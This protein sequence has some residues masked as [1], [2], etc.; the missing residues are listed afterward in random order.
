MMRTVL[1]AALCGVLA[2]C[3]AAATLAFIY[4]R[5]PALVLEFDR[6]LPRQ[7]TGVYPIERDNQTGLTYAWTGVEMGVRAPGLDRRVAWTLDVRLRAARPDGRAPEVAFFADGIHLVTQV[8]PQ[9]FGQLRVTIP[10]SAPQPGRGVGGRRDLAITMRVSDTFTPGP[11]DPRPLGVLLDRLTLTPAGIVL[12]PRRAFFS[13]AASAGILG[14][15]VALLGVTAPAAVI[16]ALLIG[17][18][19]SAL[20]ARG[21]APFGTFPL[22]ATWLALWT[23]VILVVVARAIEWRTGHALRNT[24]RFALAFSAFAAF[25]KLLVMLHPDLPIGDALFHAHRFRL[26]DSGTYVFTSIAP[27]NYRFPYAPGLYVA[28]LPFADTVTRNIGDMALLR[29]IVIA[30]DAA[31]AA[32]LYFA[33]VRAWGDRLAAAIAVALYHLVPLD[34]D[35]ATVGNLT[36]AFAQSLAVFSLVLVASPALRLERRAAVVA[37]AGVMAAAFLSH[38]STFALL[39]PAA[40]FISAAFLWKGG[41][42]LRSPAYAVAVAASIAGLFAVAIYYRHFGEVYAEQ[43]A[44]ISGETAVNAPDAGGRTPMDRLL[45]AP[46]Q[47]LLMFGVP[48]LA[49]AAVGTYRLLVRS[50][51]DRLT[52]SLLGWSVSCALFFAIGIATPVDMRYY[53]AAI[54]A[55]AM[56]A[57]AGASWMWTT[58]GAARAGAAALLLWAAFT[59]VVGVLRF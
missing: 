51:R 1:R 15:A 39:L 48:V 30:F 17:G 36:N 42:A 14:A 59:G 2:A 10:T 35:I 28:A 22:H 56:T 37:L 24:A 21:F 57:A 40:A 29:I 18:G 41:P 3:L 6:D 55:V 47:L 52:L 38:T 26:V 4:A 23:A 34:F 25:V 20:V 5:W 49:L 32:L 33:V 7:V 46:R 12:P 16:A 9:E 19:T 43:W 50:A 11:G 54:P 27:G 58:N 44:R 13:A 8:A 53:L 45:D 31:A